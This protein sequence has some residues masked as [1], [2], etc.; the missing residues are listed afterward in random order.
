VEGLAASSTPHGRTFNACHKVSKNKRH[1]ARHLDKSVKNTPMFLIAAIRCLSYTE[2]AKDIR[3]L[4]SEAGAR[5]A[6][7]FDYTRER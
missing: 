4:E 3:L 7:I 5:S 6:F 1:R 2:Y